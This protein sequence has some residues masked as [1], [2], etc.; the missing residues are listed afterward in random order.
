MPWRSISWSSANRAERPTETANRPAHCGARSWREVSAPRTTVAIRC[1]AWSSSRYLARKASK[2]HEGPSC[3]FDAR[4][5]V[6]N[7]TGILC[8][9]QHPVGRHVEELVLRVDEPGD[10]PRAVDPVDLRPLAGDPS[11]SRSPPAGRS[12][13]GGMVAPPRVRAVIAGR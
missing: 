13:R 11:H 8:H 3:S 12:G 2:L 6:G 4:D 5:V 9:G 7:G 1:R 10:Q